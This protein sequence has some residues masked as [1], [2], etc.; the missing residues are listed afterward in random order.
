MR[1]ISTASIAGRIFFEMMLLPRM[2][3][4]VFNLTPL[5]PLSRIHSGFL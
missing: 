5:I 2:G 4:F 1:L 3:I